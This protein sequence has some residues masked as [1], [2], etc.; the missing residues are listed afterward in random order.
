MIFSSCLIQIWIILFWKYFR[1]WFYKCDDVTSVST[2][3]PDIVANL[4]ILAEGF[5][6]ILELLSALSNTFYL[7]NI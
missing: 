2:L 7:L 1:W 5:R 3:N 4:I 6:I